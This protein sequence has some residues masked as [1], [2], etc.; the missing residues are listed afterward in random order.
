MK[1]TQSTP[2]TQKKELSF[3]L[4]YLFGVGDAGFNLMSN[5]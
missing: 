1:D 5:I 2:E 3:S 4:K